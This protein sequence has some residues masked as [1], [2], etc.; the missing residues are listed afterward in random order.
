MLALIMAMVMLLCA[1]PMV[2]MAEDDP[3]TVTA[4]APKTT[5]AQQL[6]LNDF[7]DTSYSLKTMSGTTID[8]ISLADRSQNYNLIINVNETAGIALPARGT[9]Y[10]RLPSEVTT[11]K[12]GSYGNVNWT[13]D[14]ENNQLVL[15]FADG[16]EGN[17]KS[18]V[19]MVEIRLGNVYDLY[20]IARID[21]TYYRMAKTKIETSKSLDEYI[22]GKPDKQDNEVPAS[23]YTAAEY[24]FGDITL[25][26]K[27]SLSLSYVLQEE[28]PK[29]SSTA[30]TFLR[31]C[32]TLNPQITSSSKKDSGK[33]MLSVT[34][35]I[36]LSHQVRIAL[37]TCRCRHVARCSHRSFHL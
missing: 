25:N 14:A 9:F 26:E 15:Q 24:D 34:I 2:V 11:A 6:I 31:H 3:Q 23:E 30:Q 13:Y 20:N 28:H 19:I 29:V 7:M 8:N 16:V 17:Q 4:E 35:G 21:G 32:S 18:F 10:Y 12:D 27:S 22:A 33:G 37:F 5:V 1:L 36:N